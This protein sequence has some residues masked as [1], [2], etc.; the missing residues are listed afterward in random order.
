VFTNFWHARWDNPLPSWQQSPVRSYEQG[1]TDA[2]SSKGEGA[3]AIQFGSLK[4]II[5]LLAAQISM[6]NTSLSLDDGEG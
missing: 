2:T 1:K 4:R 5:I 3:F 6:V